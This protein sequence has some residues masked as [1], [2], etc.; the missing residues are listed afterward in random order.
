MCKSRKISVLCPMAGLVALGIATSVI[1][2]LEFFKT[3]W[4]RPSYLNFKPC[5]RSLRSVFV[6]SEINKGKPE[7]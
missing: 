1:A 6:H 2:L 3:Q 4:Q 5:I 7:V